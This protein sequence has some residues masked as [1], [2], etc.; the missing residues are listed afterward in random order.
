[1]LGNGWEFCAVMLTTAENH[2]SMCCPGDG[3]CPLLVAREQPQHRSPQVSVF[4]EWERAVPHRCL[5][6]WAG[7]RGSGCPM[8]GSRGFAG[9]CRGWATALSLLH[10]LCQGPA[11]PI[12][13][14]CPGV[15]GSEPPPG[16]LF[17]Q[18]SVPCVLLQL[19]SPVSQF[20]RSAFGFR[21]SDCHPFP[22]P[23]S[24]LAVGIRTPLKFPKQDGNGKSS[25]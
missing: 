20:Y 25:V 10:M 18:L 19:L 21:V 12:R 16:Q 2:S 6:W 5:P 7:E 13:L 9:T 1:M 11:T 22:N 15:R 24:R 4:R 8:S 17:P 14:H 3:V 23:V